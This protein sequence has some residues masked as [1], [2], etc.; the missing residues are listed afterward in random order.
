MQGS[1][2]ETNP[3]ATSYLPI[4]ETAA[5][6]SA[7]PHSTVERAS[8]VSGFRDPD[9]AAAI[10]ATGSCRKRCDGTPIKPMFSIS[11]EDGTS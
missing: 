10:A 5:A 6:I 2:H 7:A 1:C 8:G 9:Y 3:L 11:T 4:P